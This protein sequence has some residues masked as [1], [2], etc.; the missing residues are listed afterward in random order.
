MPTY[1]EG[2]GELGVTLAL[3]LGEKR[4]GVA[5]SDALGMLARPLVTISYKRQADLLEQIDQL[6]RRHAAETVV[7]GLPKTL[8]NDIGP[9]A[10]RVLSFVQVL[11]GA[12]SVPIETWD[13]RFTTAEA[14]RRK[15][16]TDPHGR[17]TN[18]RHG[19]RGKDDDLDARAAAVLLESYL[20]S[21]T[22]R[23]GPD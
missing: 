13:E 5:V 15:Q 18:A 4:V 16:E 14:T 7:V 3:D 1:C 20:A 6:V 21:R 12:I 9:Q 23:R 11:G 19:Q 2:C 17:R 10:Q 8:R 22:N